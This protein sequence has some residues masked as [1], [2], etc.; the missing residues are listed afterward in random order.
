MGH[1]GAEGDAAL[2]GGAVPVDVQGVPHVARVRRR[3]SGVAAGDAHGCASHDASCLFSCVCG[4]GGDDEHSAG[5]F[6]LAST[7]GGAIVYRKAAAGF[8]RWAEVVE[9]QNEALDKLRCAAGA[10][11]HR[12]TGMALR[13]WVEM[14]CERAE[15]FAKMQSALGSLMHGKA[16]AGFRRWV[17]SLGEESEALGKLRNAIGHMMHRQLSAGLRRWQWGIQEQRVMQRCA[18]ALF[19]STSKAFRTWLEYADEQAALLQAMRRA[20]LRIANLASSRAFSAWSAVTLEQQD[21][22]L[23]L[24]AAVARMMHGQLGRALSRWMEASGERRAALDALRGGVGFWLN[25]KVS[26]AF[27]SIRDEATSKASAQRIFSRM[28]NQSLARCVRG[29]SL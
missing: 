7:C 12:E 25:R 4:V 5:S 1:S 22:Q 18:A 8:R 10:L 11:K 2:R 24:R 13:R 29:S 3:A 19:Q 28:L 16:A 15:A 21:Q 14:A 17:E 6:R 27:V 9:E 23:L 26:S 20:A